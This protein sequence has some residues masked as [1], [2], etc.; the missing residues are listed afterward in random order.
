MEPEDR[1]HLCMTCGRGFARKSDLNRHDQGVHLRVKTACPIC[2]ITLGSRR[3]WKLHNKRFHEGA[4]RKIRRDTVATVV[5]PAPLMANEDVVA[6]T[7]GAVFSRRVRWESPASGRVT[8]GSADLVPAAANLIAPADG[9]MPTLVPIGVPAN[10]GPSET[11][12]GSRGDSS[13]RVPLVNYEPTDDEQRKY[14]TRMVAWSNRI[15]RELKEID[16]V[17]WVKPCT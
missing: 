10:S 3:A 17:E 2:N 4:T 14:R 16:E 5:V 1:P 9:D 13:A 6:S 8:L 7:G 15:A 11:A 12:A